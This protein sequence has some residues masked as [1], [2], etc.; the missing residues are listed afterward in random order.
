M[1][2]KFC[3]E[4]SPHKSASISVMSALLAVSGL[5]GKSLDENGASHEL[6]ACRQEKRTSGRPI[7]DCRCVVG[8]PEVGR[9]R[10]RGS[11]GLGFRPEVGKSDG[12]RNRGLD[13]TLADAQHAFAEASEL[14]AK[15]RKNLLLT[16]TQRCFLPSL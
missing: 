16:Q 14:L 2:S 7:T 8:Q 9:K 10:V 12:M 5:H 15:P 11:V 3:G 6:A 13:L 4:I 1:S